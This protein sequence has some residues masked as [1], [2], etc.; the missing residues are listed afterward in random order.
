MQTK[1]KINENKI[2]GITRQEQPSRHKTKPKR[3]FKP[4]T[5]NY[6]GCDKTFTPTTSAQL[7]CS[8]ECAKYSRQ[9]HTLARVRRYRKKYKKEQGVGTGNLG[10]HTRITEDTE[11]VEIEAGKISKEL[12]RL[13]IY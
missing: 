1:W 6:P 3:H 4:R 2:T 10:E 11:T 5:C 13:K 9:D 8:T 12:R 7:Y